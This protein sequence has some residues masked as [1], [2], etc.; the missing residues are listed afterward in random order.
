MAKLQ[1]Q[2]ERARRPVLRGERGNLLQIRC[3]VLEFEQRT[4]GGAEKRLIRGQFQRV[5]AAAL[6]R[7][8]LPDEFGCWELE[9]RKH[10][11]AV[12]CLFPPDFHQGRTQSEPRSEAMV[13]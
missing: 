7:D 13:A 6:A 3:F 11:A 1:I 5:C 10:I 9:R 8:D 4:V 12:A 2:F